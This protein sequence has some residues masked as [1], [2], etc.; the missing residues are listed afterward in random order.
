M[1][2]T[3]APPEGCPCAADTSGPAAAPRPPSGTPAPPS[4]GAP[5]PPPSGT[6]IPPPSSTPAPPPSGTPAA[7]P[8]AALTSAA[9]LGRAAGPCSSWTG[10]G[11][12]ISLAQAAGLDSNRPAGAAVLHPAS[13]P[14]PIIW[15]FVPNTTKW[16]H[17]TPAS[18]GMEPPSA[19][20]PKPT[21]SP[22]CTA[23]RD[24]LV[25]LTKVPFELLLSMTTQPPD[26]R[27]TSNRACSREALHG[28][29]PSSNH[30]AA[31]SRHRPT[32]RPPAGT[33]VGSS[34]KSSTARERAAPLGSARSERRATS[35]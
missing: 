16:K 4:S 8:S 30:R 22:A 1:H 18:G 33:I 25:P 31:R 14:A 7:P 23:A 6:P 11:A 20:E 29:P 21:R 24:T 10:V 3:A 13:P 15:C 5:A 17:G 28:L 12:G 19:H 35:P 27:S 9:A 2:P 34:I 32:H 26:A